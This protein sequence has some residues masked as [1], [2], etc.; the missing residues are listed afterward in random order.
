LND[1]LR[2]SFIFFEFV[3]YSGVLVGIYSSL[4]SKWY[5]AIE[6][7]DKYIPVTGV[8]DKIDKKVPSFLVFIAIIFIIILFLILPMLLSFESTSTLN[9]TVLSSIGLPLNNARIEIYDNSDEAKEYFTGADGKTEIIVLGEEFTINVSKQNYSPVTKDAT[10]DE[11]LSFKLS[12]T[13]NDDPE[14]DNIYSTVLVYDEDKQFIAGS[15]LEISCDGEISTLSPSNNQFYFKREDCLI[16]QITAKASGYSTESITLPKTTERKTI[17]LNKILREGSLAI[18]TKN[19]GLIESNVEIVI[20]SSDGKTKTIFSDVS[21]EAFTKLAIGTYTYQANSRGKLKEG[22]FEITDNTITN[23]IIIFEISETSRYKYL[24]LHVKDS[25]EQKITSAEVNFY[26]NDDLIS[27]RRTDSQGKTTPLKVDIDEN[28]VQYAAVIKSQK[29]QIKVVPVTIQEEKEYQ[30]VIMINGGATLNITL[31]NDLNQPEKTAFTKLEINTFNGILDKGFSDI[32]GKIKFKNLPS[33]NYTIS[34]FDQDQMDT[35]T[36]NTTLI[37]NQTKN[38]TLRLMTG[39]GKITFEIKD[40]QMNNTDV[41]YQIYSDGN[42]IQSGRTKRGKISTPKI[43]VRS[44]VEL[45]IV[46]SEFIPH[47]TIKYTIDRTTQKKEVFVRAESELPNNKEIQMFLMNVYDTNP[48]NASY[49]DVT[50]L[51]PNKTYYLYFDVIINN[52]STDGLLSGFVAG[53]GDEVAEKGL[54]IN[55]IYSIN[56]I[57]GVMS[58]TKE[59]YIESTSTNIV[60]ENAKEAN[61]TI[62]QTN[63]LSSIPIILVV[64]TDINAE[65]SHT[66]FFNSQNSEFTSL[67]YSQEFV[68]GESFCVSGQIDCPAFLFSSY[69]KWEDQAP[70][71]LGEEPEIILIEDDYTLITTVKNITD[72]DIGSALLNAFVPK[73]KMNYINVNDTN[74]KSHQI[75]LTPLASTNAN[76]FKITPKKATS[77]AVIYQSVM[78]YIDGI[79]TLRNYE[80]NEAKLSFI[81]KSKEQLNIIVSPEQIEKDSEYPLFIIKTKYNSKYIGVPAY[82]KA[83]LV[84]DSGNEEITR[85]RT[86]ENGLEKIEFDTLD[87]STG[88]KILFTAWD[89]NGAYDGTIELTISNPFPTP[90]PIIPE[91]LRVLIGGNPISSTNSIKDLNVN[92][93]TTFSID[94][95]CSVERDIIISS[96]LPITPNHN[97][98]LVAGANRQLTITARPDNNVLGVYPVRI[99]SDDA[100]G[101][102]DL[103]TIDV[104]VSDPNSCFDLERAIFDLRTIGQ[105]SSKVTNTCYDGR[106]NNFYPK[107]DLSTNSISVQFDKPGNPQFIDF[108]AMVI[109]TAVEAMTQGGAVS[110]IHA[111]SRNSASNFHSSGSIR[112]SLGT[113]T[114]AEALSQEDYLTDYADQ[115]H[116]TDGETYPKEE[117]DLNITD[118]LIPLGRMYT[119]EDIPVGALSTKQNDEKLLSFTEVTLT[120]QIDSGDF[121]GN[122]STG[123]YGS[124]VA[125]TTTLPDYFLPKG[126]TATG[127]ELAGLNQSYR[128]NKST[129]DVYWG[130]TA[131]G[132][133]TTS[134]ENH[135]LSS[136]NNAEFDNPGG[137]MH[138][139]PPDSTPNYLEVEAASSYDDVTFGGV[140]YSTIQRWESYAPRWFGFRDGGAGRY[141]I[142]SSSRCSTNDCKIVT[143]GYLGGGVKYSQV[144]LTPASGNFSR[145]HGRLS[146]QYEDMRCVDEYSERQSFWTEEIH[147]PTIENSVQEI[148]NYSAIPVPEWTNIDEWSGGL[149]EGETSVG[150]NASFQVI[151]IHPS[152]LVPIEFVSGLNGSGWNYLDTD[153]IVTPD[154]TDPNCED[155]LNTMDGHNAIPYI[156]RPAA[157]PLVEYSSDGITMYYIP[158]DK[159]PGWSEGQPTVRMFLKDGVVYAEYIG[160]PEVAGGNIDFNITKNDLLGEEYATLTVGDWI[161]DTETDTQEF[162]I[163]LTGNEHPCYAND[164]TQGFTGTTFTPKLLFNWDWNNIAINQCDSTNGIYTYCDASQFTISLFKKLNEIENLIKVNDTDTLPGK[165]TF[166]AYLIKDNYSKEFLDD[167][168]SYYSNEFLSG[169]TTFTKLKQLISQNKLKFNQRLPNDT[170]VSNTIL[171]Y[172]GLYRVEIGIDMINENL[173]SLFDETTPNANITV[174]LAQISPAPNY[175]PFYEMP[176][177]GL[178]NNANNRNGYGVSITNDTL[179]LNQGET[180]DEYTGALRVVRHE[181]LTNLDDLDKGTV[182]IFDNNSNRLITMPSQPTPV[183]MVVTS[184]TGTVN[185]TYKIEGTGSDSAL[186]KEWKMTESTI[187]TATCFDFENQDKQTFTEYRTSTDTRKLSWNGNKPGTI[188]LKTVF[189]IPKNPADTLRIT[190]LNENT[191][192]LT[193][194]DA[195]NNATTVMLDNYDQRGIDN[196]ST[197]RGFFENIRNEKMCMSTDSKDIMKIWW[198]TEYLDQLKEEIPTSVGGAC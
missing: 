16:T 136:T 96:L 20:E 168:E 2:E 14:L 176:F 141:T 101:I 114:S 178:I 26:K 135:F 77:S 55:G 22:T 21:G 44:Q 85:G 184:N 19:F 172:G 70:I 161:S 46:D 129:M 59:N 152:G 185:A 79:D 187:G 8:I 1:R 102:V 45:K 112:F 113:G 50:K 153:C 139:N 43:K 52:P 124:F 142:V 63:G 13:I 197:L 118:P 177:N 64:T 80:D 36:T 174:R 148:G 24:A 175:N 71:A 105:L 93:T 134:T 125:G 38:V 4:E 159:I 23:K 94:S 195:L 170:I 110:Y 156:T 151:D 90:P 126:A 41:N 137:V 48:L 128:V 35:A 181:Q 62:N 104:I 117:P 162:Y 27:V 116:Y 54:S 25:N 99:I 74:S 40:N 143:G 163:K 72:Q 147:L 111:Y 103:G 188:A 146:I 196:Y 132:S 15:I 193:S 167:F 140:D 100:T 145:H 171:P 9:V 130:P 121:P 179:Q 34:A 47:K 29:Y 31:I 18:Q 182:L 192:S 68:I 119:L 56:G 120:T 66:L 51:L 173:Y 33:G 169:G 60:N 57:H 78:K 166:Y 155:L 165:T 17:E 98:T 88:D 86:D 122:M 133:S 28:N 150:T 53:V 6:A 95:N 154:N 198:N 138:F 186:L 109:G 180:G 115:F 5:S 149:E 32:N 37:P 189:L 39:E 84:T 3:I 97:I 49:H 87:F 164:G 7:V 107:M 89:N 75:T 61:L 123:V 67:D 81:V 131:P 92:T 194:Y 183:A 158:Q 127:D 12:A 30:E 58:S 69:L 73:E 11:K 65:G 190:P 144:K 106:F 10:I 191:T 82:W 157:D 76:E 91:C 42:M 83:E 160:V 108:N